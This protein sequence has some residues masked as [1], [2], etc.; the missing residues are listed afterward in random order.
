MTPSSLTRKA[1]FWKAYKTEYK[2][3]W[4]LGLPVLITQVGIIVV[5]FADTMM[6]GA[7]GTNELAAAAFVN[8]IFLVAIVMQIGFAAGMTPLI[9][10]LYS[11]KENNEVGVTLRGGLQI[12]IFVS[13][14]FTAIMASLYFFLDRFG[15]PEELLPL[16]RRYYLMQTGLEL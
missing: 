12:N 1:G 15:Q 14:A 2:N 10:A 11:R 5:S 4:R 7:Y 8:S 3:L 16:I 6:V 9:G 13:L